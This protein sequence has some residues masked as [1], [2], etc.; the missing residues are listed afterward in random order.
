MTRD[1]LALLLSG[2]FFGVLVGWI[3]GSQ[4]AVSPPPPPPVAAAS[5]PAAPAAN[6]PAPA[7]LD[8]GRVAQLEARANASPSD[9]GVRTE[10]GNLYFDAERYDDAMKWYSAALALDP[11]N[12]N[13]STDL[14]VAYYYTN[15]VDRALKQLDYSLSIDPRHL[16]SLLNQGI[17]LAWGKQDLTGAQAAWERLVAIAPTSEEGRRAAQ[18]LDGIRAAHGPEGATAPAQP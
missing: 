3:I 8:T 2:T 10:L 4:Q 7:A 1:S 12:V 9:A 18:G 17:V 13:V 11:R 15:Q 5:A 16:K 6:T 14:A